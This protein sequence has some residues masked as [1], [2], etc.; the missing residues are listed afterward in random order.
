MFNMRCRKQFDFQEKGVFDNEL[1]QKV[2]GAGMI[3]YI[4]DENLRKRKVYLYAVYYF[5]LFIHTV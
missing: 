2:I 5:I 4:S 1:L 3:H